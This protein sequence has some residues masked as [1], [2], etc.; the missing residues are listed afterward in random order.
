MAAVTPLQAATGLVQQHTLTSS[1]IRLKVTKSPLVTLA[2]YAWEGV[3]I[4]ILLMNE[5]LCTNVISLEC[6]YLTR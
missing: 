6:F 1:L 2:E 5:S 4:K 3:N